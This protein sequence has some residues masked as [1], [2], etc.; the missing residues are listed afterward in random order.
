MRSF[1]AASVPYRGWR[2]SLLG[3][4]TALALL[5]AFPAATR[6]RPYTSQSPARHRPATRAGG[7]CATLARAVAIAAGGDTIQFG[8]GDFVA[9]T[10]MITKPLTFRGAKA[11]VPGNQR[12]PAD[13]T[14]LAQETVLKPTGDGLHVGAT[15]T[16]IDGLVFSGSTSWALWTTGLV[17]TDRKTGYKIRNNIFIGN[18][19]GMY[20]RDGLFD[21]IISDNLFVNNGLGGSENLRTAI[22]A[23]DSADDVTISRN[24][25]RGNAMSAS[26]V[27]TRMAARTSPTATTS[28]STTRTE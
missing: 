9:D 10:A 16:V 12:N 26:V 7:P 1:L 3:L 23:D 8:P 21:V 18:H 11:G 20:L 24:E 5:V 22:Y 17:G 6:R 2:R 14:Q 15:N 4:L 27:P 25:F 19:T 13:P 28:R